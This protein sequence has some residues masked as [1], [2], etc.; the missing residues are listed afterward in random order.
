M[1][2]PSCCS[3]VRVPAHAHISRARSADLYIFALG[4]SAGP[5][6]TL[7]T[8]WSPDSETAMS[9]NCPGSRTSTTSLNPAPILTRSSGV[10]QPMSPHILP[11]LRAVS[12]S[13]CSR[14]SSPNLLEVTLTSSVAS[15]G[16]FLAALRSFLSSLMTRRSRASASWRL[17][18][19]F[20]PLASASL[21][22]RGPSWYFRRMWRSRTLWVPPPGAARSLAFFA[23][24][25]GSGPA[26]PG[27]LRLSSVP[28]R[29]R[30]KQS[31]KAV[32]WARAEAPA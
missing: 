23:A 13:E 4:W 26:V 8:R 10:T 5:Q 19:A 31:S 14:Q 11:P 15:L 24:G 30:K 28:A 22:A 17:R 27:A 2:P 32:H 7:C 9:L 12:H 21:G 20:L 1:Y 6:A 16:A 29:G 18:K 25:G 3:C